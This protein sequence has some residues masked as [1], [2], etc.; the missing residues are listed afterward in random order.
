MPALVK[1]GM[2]QKP[3]NDLPQQPD[4]DAPSW[5]QRVREGTM[6]KN[7]MSTPGGL[8][9]PMPG[10]NAAPAPGPPKDLTAMLYGGGAQPAGNSLFGA[11][12]LVGGE[13]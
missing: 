7:R 6:Y 4:P 5:R 12:A 8:P 2:M 13:S 3:V 1:G 10:Q 11:G 9:P